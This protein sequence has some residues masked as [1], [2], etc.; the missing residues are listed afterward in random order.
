MR[1]YPYSI[2]I[3][4]S[5]LRNTSCFTSR[6]FACLSPLMYRY[7]QI[8]SYVLCCL[9]VYGNVLYARLCLEIRQFDQII[10]CLSSSA[11]VLYLVQ[12]NALEIVKSERESYSYLMVALTLETLRKYIKLTS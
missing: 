7:T 9:M 12:V 6:M 8:V 1:R 3:T 2:V 10:T 11:S 5:L 4:K